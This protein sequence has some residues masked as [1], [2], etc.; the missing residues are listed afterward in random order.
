MGAGCAGITAN[1]SEFFAL[2]ESKA[3][4]WVSTDG[5][6]WEVRRVPYSGIGVS[7]TGSLYCVLCGS[8]DVLC[9]SPDGYSWEIYPTWSLGYAVSFGA[10]VL[11]VV[12]LSGTVMTL[13]PSP[14]Q[15]PNTRTVST[16]NTETLPAAP[17]PGS[18]VAAYTVTDLP[19]I[20]ATSSASAYI[21]GS[22]TTTDRN[23]YEHENADI[24]LSCDNFVPGVGFTINATSDVRLDVDV[25][26]R[27]VWR[28]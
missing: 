22:D 24:R 6:S 25:K 8:P 1:G 18:N 12:G 21:D 16:V 5:I 26:V 9:I 17:V 23:A 20:T 28:V 2:T 7:Y 10:G 13:N 19:D 14:S 27:Y 11:C 15:L 3:E 4:A